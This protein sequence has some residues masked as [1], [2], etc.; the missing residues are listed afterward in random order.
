MACSKYSKRKNG[1][2]QCRVKEMEE[3]VEELVANRKV[4]NHFGGLELWCLCLFAIPY[5]TPF[6]STLVLLTR[7]WRKRLTTRTDW[8][9]S[10]ETAGNF[11][12]SHNA[13]FSH[14]INETVY[15]D[16]VC[17]TKWRD[18][19]WFCDLLRV[20]G[21]KCQWWDNNHWDRSVMDEVNRCSSLQLSNPLRYWLC[22]LFTAAVPYTHSVFLPCMTDCMQTPIFPDDKSV[23]YHSLIINAGAF[24]TIASV[25]LVIPVKKHK[26]ALFDQPRGTNVAEGR[27]LNV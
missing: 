14:T 11:T 22:Y 26:V 5:D 17:S 12:Q 7:K 4:L 6:L 20:F 21:D 19:R 15:A 16:Y 25:M 1:I 3:S 13:S 18:A 10:R 24:P 9:G 8:D 23:Q 2:S 27:P